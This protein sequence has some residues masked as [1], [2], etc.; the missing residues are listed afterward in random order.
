MKNQELK[1]GILF[2]LT[3]TTSITERGQYQA[4]LLAIRHIN[5]SGGINGKTLIPIVED[6]ASDPDVTYQK[7]EKLVVSDQVT[8][9]I[10]CYTA[11]CRKKVIPVLEKYN[12]LLFYPTI[13]EGEEQHPN[14]FYSNSTPNQQLLDFVP[15]LIRHVGKSFYLLGSDYI[16][17]REINRYVRH[18]VQLNGGSVYGEQYVALGNQIFDKQIGEIRQMKPDIV[19][20]TLVGDSTISYYRQH[21]NLGLPQVIA[22]NVTAETEIKAIEPKGTTDYYSCF[23]YFSSLE[24]AKNKR[25]ITEFQRI[26]G[27]DII[28]SVMESAYNSIILLAEALKRIDTTSTDSIR[29]ALAGL[30]IDAPQ[31]KIMV[32]RFNQHVW[33]NS[34]IGK[35][36]ESGQFTIIWESE[37]LIKPIPLFKDAFP[38]E[39]K[40]R[41]GFNKSNLLQSK[42]M[43]NRCLLSELKKNL[44]GLP[45]PFAYF[46]E[47]G[48][49]LE[50]F[51]SDSS[52]APSP[53]LELQPG[54]T[55]SKSPLKKN[56]IGA[57][58]QNRS[59]S[60]EVTKEIDRKSN[61]SYM[62]A[63]FPI[64]EKENVQ[65]GV[66][67][68]NI[69]NDSSKSTEHLLSSIK[70]IVQLCVKLADS[71]EEQLILTDALHGIT[72]Q[73]VEAL[74]IVKEG[75]IRFQNKRAAELWELKHD[76]I[77]SV[78]QEFLSGAKIEEHIIRRK[79]AEESFEINVKNI[80]SITYVS[81]KPL[82][83][84][85]L[86]F[87]LNA[88]ENLTTDD[89]IGLNSS[90]LKTIELARAASKIQANTLLLGESGTGKEMFARAIHN[91]SPRRNKPFVAVNCGA[92]S[93]D[94][95]NSELF[96][97]VEGAF[98]G[99]KKGGKPGKFEIANGGT[100]FLDEIG[101]M[102]LELQTTLL[103]VLQEKEVVPVGGHKPIP[104]DVRIIAA[105]NKDLFQ[106]IAFNGSFRSDLYYRLNVFTIELPPLRQRPEDIAKFSHYYLEEFNALSGHQKELSK[107]TL[108]LLVKY[109]WPG[110]IRE[111][112]NTI[113][114]AFYL[115]GSSTIITPEHLPQEI[116]ENSQAIKG[117]H[118]K[119][120]DQSLHFVKSIT[121]IKQKNYANERQF[122]IQNLMTHNGNIS[123]TARH[124]G[125]S[126]TTLYQKLKE[127]Q[128][129]TR[130]VK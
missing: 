61:R 86:R 40:D 36:N 56:G 98:T 120:L 25:F 55:I 106:E 46:D 23:S 26:Y 96:G 75:K 105:T 83:R 66:L 78:L 89:L 109:N 65:R 9:I 68:L 51:N 17:P 1:V 7:A 113:E 48:V 95:I 91:E 118:S 92:I 64:M 5:E 127:Y 87:A 82:P 42:I 77:Y 115:A 128:I 125:I 80:N 124:L 94:L 119:R 76:F 72:D 123:Q 101:E 43:Q 67:G 37:N 116:T 33:L 31:G 45:Y 34:R 16:Y 49:M 53:L 20:S 122:Y 114:R 11:A 8:A 90:F 81:F 50:T 4:C 126:R 28:S 100:L 93:K 79:D 35:V 70:S 97:Y 111:L 102:P 15:W 22:S 52:L 2:S 12:V 104:L 129:E 38:A 74:F 88:R 117:N 60:Y 130:K 73:Q 44:A 27:T 6:A 121:E 108:S 71:Q 13:N 18:L 103:R 63:G 10:G 3:G 62:A 107:E 58:F 30:S 69:P 112:G 85:Q 39:D 54:E 32:D 59:S 84:Q 29:H 21:E 24:N 14:I 19:F 110:N 57:A 47:E 99:A 41:S